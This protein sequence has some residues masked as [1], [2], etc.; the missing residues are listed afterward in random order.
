MLTISFLSLSLQ[1]KF[2]DLAFGVALAAFLV[3][4]IIRIWRI[5]PLGQL[6]HQ[7][8]NAFTDHRDSDLLIS[9]IS[10]CYWGVHFQSG[11]LLASMIDH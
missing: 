2:L 1:P 3:F 5:W 6:L 4:E 7:F 11:C 10:H 8:M 9:A